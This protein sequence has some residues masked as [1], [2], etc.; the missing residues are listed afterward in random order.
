[1]GL[2]HLQGAAWAVGLMG[3]A[4][5]SGDHHVSPPSFCGGLLCLSGE[6]PGRVHHVQRLSHQC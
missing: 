1:M 6:V 5:T 3:A 4:I 2:K